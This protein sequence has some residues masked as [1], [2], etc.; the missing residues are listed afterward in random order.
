MRKLF[1]SAFILLLSLSSYSQVVA[2]PAHN[3]VNFTNVSNVPQDENLLPINGV[4][5]LKVPVLNLNLMNALPVGTVKIKI[6]LGSKLVLDPDFDLGNANTSNYF[7]WTAALQGGQVQLTGE[8]KADLPANYNTIAAFRV[9]GSVLGSST[10]TANFLI[11]N[12]NTQLILSDENPNNNTSFLPYTVVD[13]IPVNF[14]GIAVKKSG[15]DIKVNFSAE[16]EV[17]VDRYEIEASR[18]GVSYIKMGQLPANRSINYNYSFE[19][20]DNI[21]ATLLRIRVKSV[22]KDGK[23]QYTE[24]KTVKGTCDGKKVIGLYP[25]PLP[26]EQTTVTIRAEEGLFN[27][28]VSLSLSDVTGKLIR[29]KSINL[30]NAQQFNFE[31]G[32]LAAGQYLVKIQDNDGAAPQVLRFQKW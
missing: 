6:G 23:M 17:N 5:E 22:D 7:N 27:G 29:T 8:L 13:V 31:T 26:K 3:Q 20:T 15:C 9:K 28:T 21:K 18:D 2:D 30:I 16:G 25:N 11:T 14:T 32:Y 1:F 24:V 19:L 4:V 12:H 10:V